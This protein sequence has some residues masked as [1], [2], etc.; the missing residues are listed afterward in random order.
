VERLPLGGQYGVECLGLRASSHKRLAEAAFTL[1]GQTSSGSG[2]RW[3]DEYE[4]LDNA[5]HDYDEGVCGMLVNEARAVQRIATL[6]WVLVQFVSLSAVLGKESDEARWSAARL[7][8]DLYCEN[9]VIEERAWAHGSLAELWLLRLGEPNLSL[10]K[11]KEFHEKAIEHVRK[12]VAF[13]LGGDAFPVRSTRRQFERYINW[14]GTERF[15]QGLVARG[16]QHRGGWDEEFGLIDTAKSLVEILRRNR[17]E[18]AGAPEG[19]PP[20]AP[21]AKAPDPTFSGPT[22][23]SGEV[24]STVQVPSE[25]VVPEPPGEGGGNSPKLRRP[26]GAKAAQ[27]SQ[28][29]RS[30]PF[31]QIEM[32]PAGHGDALWIE[33]GDQGSI[34]RWMVDCGTQQ[35]AKELNRRVQAVPENERFLELFIMSHIDS[36]HIGGALP[37]LKTIKEEL[38]LGDVWFNGWRHLSGQLGSRQGEMFSTAIQDFELPW[39]KWLDGGTI[40]VAGDKLPECVLPGGMRLVLLSPTPAQLKKLAPVWTRELKRYGLE[41]GARVD[42]SRFLKGKPSTSTDVDQLADSPFAGDGGVPN[43]SSIAVLAEFGGTSAL[44]S[45]DAHAPVLAESIRTLLRQRG[46]DKL[47]LDACKVSHHASQNNLSTELLKLLDCPR[48][49]VS[50]NGDHFSHP[51]RE[52]IARIIK[53]GGSRP[54]LHFNYR[55]KYNEVWARPDLQERYGYVAFYPEGD[56][57]GHQVE[58]FGEG[59]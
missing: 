25:P 5:L 31:F 28:R 17:G 9:P 7:C 56:M 24:A 34:H 4:L 37:F 6:H 33:Y 10:E 46:A 48:Y 54:S 19:S 35:T 58:L 30:G 43:G 22:K 21:S 8:A 57:E 55:S 44:L 36:D 12:L 45:A 26:K 50:T 20:S 49:L 40:V 53:Y 32:L 27:P 38:K 41:P 13:Y 14:W 39:N 15:K 59:T 51:D 52:A 42:Y 1:S 47:K 18:A 2:G 29:I 3:R 23:P 11:R 16:I